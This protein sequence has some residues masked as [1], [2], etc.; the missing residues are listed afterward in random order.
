MATALTRRRFLEGGAGLTFAFTLGGGVAGRAGRALA[1]AAGVPLNIW[2]TIATDGTITIVSPAAEM[3]Q[4]TMTG[5]PLVVAEELDADWAKVKIVQ[6][7]SN[8]AYGNPG[9]G[10]AQV[11]GASRTTP[12]YWMV[13]R[14]A[15]A[16]ARRVLLDAVAAEWKVPVGELTTGPSVVIHAGS[17]RRI[18]YGD[19]AK[20]AKVPATLPKIAEADLKQPE[21]F[22]LIGRSVPRVDLPDKVTGKATFGIDVQVPD[23]LIASV[24]RAP[25][26]GSGPERVDDAA[27]K[28]V[29]GVTHVIALPWGVGVVGTGF[30]A[31]QKGKR[32]LKV[33]WKQG[34]PAEKYDTDVVRGEYAAVAVSAFSKAGLDVFSQGDAKGA[35]GKALRTFSALY[36]TDHVYHA[37]MEPMTCTASVRGDACELWLGTQAPTINQVAA[38]RAL[39]STPDKV[40]VNTVLLGGGFGRRLEQDFVLDAVLLSKATARP[41]KVIWAREDDVRNDKMRPLTAQYLTAG[42]DAEGNLSAWRHRIVA[43]SIYARFNPPLYAQLKGRDI[44]V[45]EGHEL[46]YAVANQLHELFREERGY[47]VGLWRSVGPGYTKFAIESFVDEIARAQGI[48]PVQWRLRLLAHNTRATRVV[49]AA[50]RMADWERKRR[51]RAL[52]IAMSDTWRSFIATVAEVSV[53]ARKGT[54]RVHHL[55]AA[56]DPGIAIQPDIVVAQIEGASVF[57]LSHALGERITVKGGAV[58][59][60]NFHDYPLLRMADAPEIDVDVLSSTVAPGGIGEVGLPPIAPAVANAVAA[61]TGARVRLLPMLPERVLAALRDVPKA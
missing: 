42:L 53:D 30:E 34:V 1:Q 12:G 10:G 20:F 22:R 38:S 47:D 49:R 24:L 23:M 5:M 2:V 25:V 43:A 52:G 17:G 19:V 29:K 26:P 61:L 58:Q 32:A 44:P 4:G 7:P 33:T 39:G 48:D 55:W 8:R 14:Q 37:T 13:L 6:A 15:G 51:G 31:V 11:T 50:A 54:I 28:A 41:V 18:A 9:F 3:G 36:T 59:Q 60:S 21:Q 45:I 27:A 56:V 16:Q 40:K 35:M 46:S 57:G